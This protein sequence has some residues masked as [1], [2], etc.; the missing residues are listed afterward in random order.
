MSV[1]TDLEKVI[2][3]LCKDY[4][5]YLEENNENGFRVFTDHCTGLTLFLKIEEQTNLSFYF[6]LRTYDVVYNGDRSDIH[7]V[8]SL[9]F[10]S[11]LRLYDEG[12]SCSLYDIPHPVIEDEIWGRYIMPEQAP[13]FI[14]ISSIVQLTE[15]VSNIIQTVALWRDIFWRFASCPSEECMKLEKIENSNEYKLLEEFEKEIFSVLIPSNHVNYGIRERPSL[16]YLYDMQNEITLI[17]SSELILYLEFI[18]DF[19]ERNLEQIEGINGTLIIDSEIQNY[20]D[21]KTIKEFNKLTKVL[22]FEKS[23]KVIHNFIILEN[24]V[25]AISAPYIIALG[26]LCGRTE[27]KSERELL[28]TRHNKESELLF[29]IPLFEWQE[30]PCP[31][32]F[33]RLIKSLLEREPNVK[34]VR[35]PAPTNQGDKGRDLIVEWNVRNQYIVSETQPPISLI[36]VVG[37]CKVSNLTI[38]KNKVIDIRDT[39]E[40]HNSMGYFLAVSSQISTALTEK[41]EELRSK[42]IWTSWWNREDIEMRLSKN[43]DLLPMFTKVLRAKHSIKYIEK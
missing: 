37:Q 19:C 39:V 22:S 14:G 25:I 38:G 13:A 36:R 4:S 3:K 28:R 8:M 35:I 42:G 23:T 17:K 5:L 15:K 6:L 12:I 33:E 27:F 18:Q 30:K 2:K 34:S 21:R 43:Q 9:M 7:V 11:F 32:Q 31:N 20:I 1:K 26:R 29:P 16:N 10:S 41:L 24:M 40:T